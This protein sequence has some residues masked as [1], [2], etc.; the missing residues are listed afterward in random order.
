M[1]K[2]SRDLFIVT[3]KAL[4]WEAASVQGVRFTPS[5]FVSRLPDISPFL[6]YPKF[7]ENS[8]LY[9][10]VR[11]SAPNGAEMI[12]IEVKDLRTF[13]DIGRV[14]RKVSLLGHVSENR[15]HFEISLRQSSV[16][17]TSSAG[18]SLPKSTRRNGRK[19]RILFI[20]HVSPFDKAQGR[21]IFTFHESWF[22][23][24]KANSVRC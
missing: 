2:C 14:S 17:A 3:Y 10:S 15:W 4:S 21:L 24:M 20:L 11:S 6:L 5:K 18:L 1:L 12:R 19:A 8:I 22:T 7:V 23:A 9:Q 13:L 16:Q